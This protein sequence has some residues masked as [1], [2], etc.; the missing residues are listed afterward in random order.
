MQDIE[1]KK[2][3]RKPTLE[4]NPAKVFELIDETEADTL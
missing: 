1:P 2:S 3:K 4:S